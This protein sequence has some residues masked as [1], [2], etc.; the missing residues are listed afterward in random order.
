MNHIRIL[1]EPSRNVPWQDKPLGYEGV[2]WRHTGNPITAWNPTGKTAR[3]FNSAVLPY[4]GGFVGIFRADHKNGKPQLHVGWSK[5]GLKWD[6]EDD[7]IHWKDANGIAYQ[8]NYAYD[9]RL[10]KLDDTYYVIWCTDFGGAA[11]GM[12]TTL[13]FDVW[14]R[15]C[16]TSSG[17]A[18]CL[19]LWP[20]AEKSQVGPLL[21]HELMPEPVNWQNRGAAQ[22]CREEALAHRLGLT[23]G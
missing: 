16:S 1:G 15:A 4:H 23:S 3:V 11:L 7:E 14:F 6:I 17:A 12:G 18:P 13:D 20:T 19:R 5:D 8:P 21:Q 2:V 10:V 9:P 22:G